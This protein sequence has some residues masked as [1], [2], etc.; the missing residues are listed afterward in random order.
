MHRLFVG[1]TNAA[2]FCKVYLRSLML[3]MCVRPDVTEVER[4]RVK[5]LSLE[6]I[7]AQA[8]RNATTDA[9]QE[10]PLSQQTTTSEPYPTEVRTCW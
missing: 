2:R 7:L 6:D 10:L 4:E 1:F 9:S 8:G 3:C 5:S